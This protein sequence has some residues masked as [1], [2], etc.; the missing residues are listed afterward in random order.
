MFWIPSNC[1]K[2]ISFI[3]VFI[4]IFYETFN[5]FRYIFF[6]I[7]NNLQTIFET[8]PIH[9]NSLHLHTW[10]MMTVCSYHLTCEFQSESTLYSYLNIKELL[11]RSR[12]KIWSLSDYNWTRIHNPLVYRRTLNWPVWLNGWVFV[13]ELSGCGFETNWSHHGFYYKK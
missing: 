2:N 5:K 12:R 8:L 7:E 1:F 9:T 13:Y 10:D 6:S 3:T 4:T 11:A